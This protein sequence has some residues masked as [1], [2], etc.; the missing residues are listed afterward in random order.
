MRRQPC[1][2]L[3]QPVGSIARPRIVRGVDH[4][5]RANRIQF[6]VT[7]T[8]EQIGLRVHQRRPVAAVPQRARSLVAAVDELHIT[9]PKGNDELWHG[10]RFLRREQQVDMVR[11]QSVRV[12]RAPRVRQRFAQP[13]QV[14]PVIVFPKE[15]SL[16][17]VA[18][19][20]N[21]QGNAIEVDSGT[22]GHGPSQVKIVFPCNAL[23][24]ATV[25]RTPD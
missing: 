23:R 25:D 19:L 22:A 5:R 16:A 15:T 9:P 1:I 21:V 3:P 11:H 12:Q 6:D 17:I 20:H 10:P 18:A 24:A 13:V 14:A 8:G 4:H 7:L 2:R